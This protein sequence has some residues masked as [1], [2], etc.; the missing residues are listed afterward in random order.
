MRILLV[1]VVLSLAGAAKA[2]TLRGAELVEALRGGGYN[3]YFRHAETDWSQSDRL[4]AAGEW[5]SCDPSR[6]R[7]LADK[8]HETARRI[9]AAFRRLAIPV[10]AVFSSEYC[11]SYETARAMA[12]GE[13]TKSREI[14]NMRAADFLGGRDAV[15]RRAKAMLAIPPAEGTNAVLVAHGN[16]M[17]AATGAYTGEA[18]AVVLRPDGESFV[19]VA[20]VL[21]ADWAELAETYAE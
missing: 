16:L 5:T 4:T 1:L 21:P 3:I 8:G 11:R 14:M 10:G 7:Q 2:D 17:R 18:G 19:L 20:E 6:M 12:L 15:T 9:G 13:V